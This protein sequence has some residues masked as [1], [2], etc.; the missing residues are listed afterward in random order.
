[1]FFRKA[2]SRYLFSKGWKPKMVKVGYSF[3]NKYRLRYA[4]SNYGEMPLF[5]AWWLQRTLDSLS[6]TPKSLQVPGS[7]EEPAKGDWT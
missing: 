5:R 4:I 2:M 3:E 7:N 1:M 6:P